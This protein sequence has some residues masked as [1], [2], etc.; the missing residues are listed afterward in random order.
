MAKLGQTT[1]LDLDVSQTSPG[2][3][4]APQLGEAEANIIAVPDLLF[5]LDVRNQPAA[6]VPLLRSR[7]GGYKIEKIGTDL[8]TTIDADAV[9]GM[10]AIGFTDDPH[11]LSS[12]GFSVPTSSFTLVAVLNLRDTDPACIVGDGVGFE[13][14][15]LNFTFNT[16]ATLRFD[17]ASSGTDKILNSPQGAVATDGSE[18]SIVWASYSAEADT[19]AIGKNTT[20]PIAAGGFSTTHKGSPGMKIGYLPG[21][22]NNGNAGSMDLAALLVM[23]RAGHA[24][25]DPDGIAALDTVIQN[26]GAL[27]GI[28]LG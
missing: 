5:W 4:I 16:N 26:L 2:L 10:P 13:G 21:A 8:S 1:L 14:A 7:V 28:T 3:P 24:A 20:T 23:G 6:G 27:Y 11:G 22:P 19:G 18:W 12:P 25:S 15:R 17:F 9:N